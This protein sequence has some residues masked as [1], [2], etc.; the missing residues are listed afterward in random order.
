LSSFVP[1]SRFRNQRRKIGSTRARCVGLRCGNCSA[2]M[3]SLELTTIYR[4]NTVRRFAGRKFYMRASWLVLSVSW[5]LGASLCAQTKGGAS[6]T[7]PNPVDIAVRAAQAALETQTLESRLSQSNAERLV[8]A[9]STLAELDADE[10]KMRCVGNPA[11]AWSIRF[12][13]RTNTRISPRL[14]AIVRDYAKTSPPS[15]ETPHSALSDLK[16]SEAQQCPARR[17]INRN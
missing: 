13:T 3:I 9:C 12:L 11:V 10:H 1:D 15:T 8:H 6:G 16:D 14:V 7:P 5:L 4:D 2:L 17:A